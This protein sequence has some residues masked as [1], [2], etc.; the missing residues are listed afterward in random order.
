M[1]VYMSNSM[2]HPEHDKHLCY[3]IEHGTLKNDPEVYKGLIKKG[4]YY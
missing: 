4:Q 1:E 3:L 2:P